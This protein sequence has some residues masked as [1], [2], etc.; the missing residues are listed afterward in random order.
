[1][2]NMR[3]KVVSLREPLK[4]II[5]VIICAAVVKIVSLTGIAAQIEDWIIKKSENGSFAA[6]ELS[7]AKDSG[8]REK[9][10]TKFW[11]WAVFSETT[12][13]NVVLDEEVG[14]HP[15]AVLASARADEDIPVCETPAV[16]ESPDGDAIF[17]GTTPVLDNVGAKP[18]AGGGQAEI[19]PADAR[20]V[21][22]ITISPASPKGYD[23]A[24]GV[25][26]KNDTKFEIDVGALL[27]D[28]LGFALRGDGPDVLIIHTHTSESFMPD[29]KNWYVPTDI[30]RTEDERYNV[31]RIG[32]EMEKILKDKGLNVVH[33]KEL[34][35]YPTYSGSYTRTLAD[36]EK[37]MK[38][39][40]SIKVIIDVHRDSLTREDGTMLRT[41]AEINGKKAAQVMLVMGTS[42]GGLSH[43][44]WK[45]NLRLA[46]KIQKVIDERYPTLARPINLRTER[47]N[48]HVTTGSMIAE[49][50]CSG[51]TLDEA[52][53]AA[54]MFADSVGDV[55]KTVKK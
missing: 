3:Y 36:I 40:P 42:Q 43:E 35:D 17:F 13:L 19:A 50:G 8:A 24:S 45:E 5:F 10:G 46:V 12:A 41:I 26:I 51:N 18:D 28:K 49:I 4:K 34:H 38:K 6:S 37:I 52:L 53:E 23:Y 54:R 30:E 2:R 39:Y 27:K 33:N 48:Q 44:K 1:M 7:G 14:D 20:P 25:Y 11:K 32:A 15:D 29:V 16:A 31:V 47:F 22:D 9:A 21:L 55:L